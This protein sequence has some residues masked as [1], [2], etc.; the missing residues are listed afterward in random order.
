MVNFERYFEAP[1]GEVWQTLKCAGQHPGNRMKSEFQNESYGIYGM[2]WVFLL[3]VNA[4]PSELVVD[5]GL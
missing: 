4:W 5:I 3:M 1:V 2:P